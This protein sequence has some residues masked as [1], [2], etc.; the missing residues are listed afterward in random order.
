MAETNDHGPDEQAVTA[1]EE[2]ATKKSIKRTSG[3]GRR[4]QR[5]LR[6]ARALYEEN[7]WQENAEANFLIHE[8]EVLALMDLAEVARDNREPAAPDA[9]EE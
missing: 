9:N 2:A 1:D 5:S 6:R 3:L 8:A 7:E 4:A